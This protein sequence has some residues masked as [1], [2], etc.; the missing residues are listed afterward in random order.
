M[1]AWLLDALHGPFTATRD[2]LCCDVSGCS[3]SHYIGSG[4][5][6][7]DSSRLSDRAKDEDPRVCGP[8][9]AATTSSTTWDTGD[10]QPSPEQQHDAPPPSPPPPT[11]A[12]VP[13][14]PSSIDMSITPQVLACGQRSVLIPK[15]TLVFPAWLVLLPETT[16]TTT[17]TK[18]P[19]DA[20]ATSEPPPFAAR[21]RSKRD[22]TRLG[23]AAARNGCKKS[24]PAAGR[25]DDTRG[26]EWCGGGS[27]HV[28]DDDDLDLLLPSLPKAA[29]DRMVRN[30]PWIRPNLQQQVMFDA[31]ERA[32]VDRH[33]LLPERI[34]H[35][36]N[37]WDVQWTKSLRRMDDF[38]Q[39]IHRHSIIHQ[40]RNRTE[41][42]AS[43]AP[44]P[45]A[46]AWE[47]FCRPVDTD[48]LLPG[49]DEAGLGEK[50]AAP[51]P[52]TDGAAARGNALGQYFCSPDSAARLVDL[53]LK[54]SRRRVQRALASGPVHVTIVEPSCGDGRLLRQLVDA[55]E[56]EPLLPPG[57]CS[58]STLR[59][60]GM[61]VD[62]S[63][64]GIGRRHLQRGV[65]DS[66]AVEFVTGDFLSSRRGTVG[67][68][69]NTAVDVQEKA[70]FTANRLVLMFGGPPYSAGAGSVSR[71]FTGSLDATGGRS[72]DATATPENHGLDPTDAIMRR[73][74]P[75]QFVRHAIEE[76]GAE[77]ICFLMPER[78]RN[79]GGLR[80]LLE[81]H[82]YCC[83]TL[84]CDS[85]FYFQGSA[86][87]GV[88]QPSI[89]Q[90]YRRNS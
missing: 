85:L 62:D 17:K 74:L 63:V 45:L 7:E 70:F 77:A 36:E 27:S 4:S 19:G 20:A 8:A 83:T 56:R 42:G 78:C 44:D 3:W 75:L 67:I 12:S 18:T 54:E 73:D 87:R 53:F 13:R 46:A 2:L 71:S 47:E 82:D 59:I 9:A 49:R 60:V 25:E 11:F 79:C 15:S 29:M 16:T 38:L 50:E 64:L 39:R 88:R 89:V 66:P 41:H 22:W 34:Q 30:V 90:C 61:D 31:D 48:N 43:V 52:S 28:A 35:G 58:R 23:R 76:H 72:S 68:T 33:R 51:P 80:E 55:M 84:E 1:M 86:D 32:A 40:Q 65:N 26:L 57:G 10:D 14:T 6:M 37:R 21:W 69:K 81:R 24:G 5:V